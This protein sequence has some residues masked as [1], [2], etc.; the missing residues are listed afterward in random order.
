MGAAEWAALAR[1]T[2]LESAGNAQKM[3]PR[4]ALSLVAQ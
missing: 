3:T 1:R 2:A 4:T